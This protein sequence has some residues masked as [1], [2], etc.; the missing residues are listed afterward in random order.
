MKIIVHDIKGFSQFGH[1]LRLCDGAH[2]L[3]VF[4]AAAASQRCVRHRVKA[5]IQER[6][7]TAGHDFVTEIRKFDVGHRVALRTSV[8]CGVESAVVKGQG[9]RH[10]DC[11]GRVPEEI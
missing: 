4:F 11:S 3:A 1:A 8:T 2:V 10:G 7:S 5:V 9:C 6:V